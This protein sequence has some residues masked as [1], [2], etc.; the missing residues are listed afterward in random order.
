M[1]V[2]GTLH[3]KRGKNGGGYVPYLKGREQN[4]YSLFEVYISTFVSICFFDS[5]IRFPKIYSKALGNS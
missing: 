3:W 4:S 1:I 2:F 5:T